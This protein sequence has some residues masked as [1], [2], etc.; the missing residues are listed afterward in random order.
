[1][2]VA[3]PTFRA[4]ARWPAVVLWA[5]GVACLAGI[6]GHGLP[7]EWVPARSVALLV[8]AL[9][10]AGIARILHR[11]RGLAPAH[12]LAIAWLLALAWLGGPL[13]MLAVALV[14]LA[15]IATGSLLLPR[16][17]AAAQ[18]V[19]GLALVAGLAGWLLPLPVHTRWSWLAVALVLV[20]WRHRA[21]QASLR[22]ALAQWRD[23]VAAAPRPATLAVMLLGLAATGCWVPTA[24]QDDVA[25]HLLLPW[26]LQLD[27]RLAMDPDV[28]VW[29]LAP[30]AADVLQAIPQLIAGAE[31][32]GALNALWLLLCA[33]ALWRLAG[34]LGG[35]RRARAWTVALF[36]SLPLTAVLAMG[37][38]TELPTA[39]LLCWAALPGCTAPSRRTLL[40]ACALTGMLAA[41]KLVAFG[42]AML[43]LPWLAWR[44]RSVLDARSVAAGLGL[45]LAIGG[46]SYAY[47][48]AIAGNP[49]LP[50][51][52]DLFGSPWFGGD[53]VDERWH[54]GFGPTLP[55]RMTFQTPD[56][57]EAHAGGGGFVLVALG[58]AW[59]LALARRR[60]RA[61][62]ALALL[63]LALPL[64]ATQYLRYAYPAMVLALPPL[65][66]AAFAS[67]PR[68]GHVVVVATCIANL[69]FQAN[70]HWM[71]RTGAV[72]ESLVALGRDAPLLAEYAPER[73][74]AQAVRERWSAEG[75][76]SGNLL[77][78]DL[79]TP[80]L[81]EMASRARAPSWYD[82]SLAAAANIAD[83]DASGAAWVALWQREGIAEL[84]LHAERLPAPRRAALRLAGARHEATVEGIEWWRLPRPDAPAPGAIAP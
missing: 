48:W 55:W 69:L 53:F 23:T 14:A 40:A 32:R 28:H 18:C 73:L 2:S 80:M 6:L 70:G 24:Q 45:L 67:A 60:T 65:V 1:M 63:M 74:L 49:V 17:D 25:Y 43:L 47:A 82:P 46:S 79:D 61:L 22:T 21:L 64:L 41:T 9:G 62:A 37:M 8:I 54:K 13:P 30:W 75:G 58:G 7:A 76:P 39:A 56:Y 52:N 44:H 77:V 20:V 35:D 57:L 66:V 4:D 11:V 59:L 26:S 84:V 29:A 36:G 83:A 42:F 31:A 5:G 78:L 68:S 19:T 3:T 27:G 50:L 34:A 38:Q 12:G 10:A 15:A 72:K 16:A 51:M 71:L 81:A 33:C